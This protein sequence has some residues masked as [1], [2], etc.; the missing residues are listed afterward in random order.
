M[1]SPQ[2]TLLWGMAGNT[3]H[4]YRIRQ[5]NINILLRK[6]SYKPSGSALFNIIHLHEACLM[7][8]LS[9]RV[10]DVL[11][12]AKCLLTKRTHH[13]RIHLGFLP[14]FWCTIIN[15]RCNDHTM[16]SCA[17]SQSN[18]A[19]EEECQCACVNNITTPNIFMV[20]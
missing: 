18:G 9:S 15:N 6:P 20:V 3:G 11:I 4:I 13:S 16:L 5:K 8:N 17:Y 12:S 7:P 1:S 14:L 19:L 10:Q 2:R